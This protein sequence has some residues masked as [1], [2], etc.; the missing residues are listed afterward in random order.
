MKHRVLV[1]AAAVLLAIVLAA[2]A[3]FIFIKYSG[4]PVPAPVIPRGGRTLGK[5]PA[6][7]YVVMGDSTAIGQGAKYENSYAVASADH[8]A[9]DYQVNFAN[10]GVSGAI[11]TDVLATQLKQ[12]AAYKPDL[13]LLA[14]GANDARRFVGGGTIQTALQQIVDGLKKAN[15]KVQIVVTGSPAMDAV[16]RFPWPSNKLLGLRTR[17]VNR[18]IAPII[19]KNHLTFAPVAD[20]TRAAFQADPSL[21]AADKFHPDARGYELWKPVINDALDQA[22]AK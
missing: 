12:A 22:L 8:L 13:V 6:L 14:V 3:E 17:Q 19:S 20:K 11:T 2:L 7:T 4:G 21:F 9:E 10:V 16:P 18:A 1:I 5:G 15:P